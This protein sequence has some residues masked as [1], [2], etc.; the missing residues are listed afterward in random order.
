MGT[1]CHTEQALPSLVERLPVA[2]SPLLFF[3]KEEQMVSV[4]H[5]LEVSVCLLGICCVLCVVSCMRSS[6]L[7][8]YSWTRQAA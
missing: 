6:L 3:L 8:H 1:V 7:R 2:H 5:L 4:Q